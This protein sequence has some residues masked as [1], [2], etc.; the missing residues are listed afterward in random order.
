MSE[1]PRN[2][3]PGDG[4]G[5][6]DVEPIA[7]TPRWVKVFGLIALVLVLLLVVLLLTGGHGPSR[8]SAGSSQGLA[9]R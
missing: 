5:V 7:G 1:P 6:A 4:P 2:P 3:H 9:S 8:H